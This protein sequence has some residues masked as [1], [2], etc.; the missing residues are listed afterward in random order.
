[1]QAWT[2]KCICFLGPQQNARYSLLI[3]FVRFILYCIVC[4]PHAIL[5]TTCYITL[6]NVTKYLQN[7]VDAYS[8]TLPIRQN[9]G[10]WR[11][12]PNASQTF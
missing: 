10:T 12:W 2:Y 9:I 7:V 1:M 4:L 5:Y 11:Q 8:H 6:V 3:F